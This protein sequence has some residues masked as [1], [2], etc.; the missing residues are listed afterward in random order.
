MLQPVYYPFTGPWGPWNERYEAAY[1]ELSEAVQPLMDQDG[2]T[3]IAALR[4][5]SAGEWPDILKHFEEYRFARLTAFLRARQ[6]DEEINFSILV[7]RLSDADVE[8]A[9][10]GPHPAFGP[11]AKASETRLLPTF[12]DLPGY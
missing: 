10:R 5:H 9:L 12:D 3:R 11:D 1:Q 7:Y 2:T 6:P 4:R 8:L